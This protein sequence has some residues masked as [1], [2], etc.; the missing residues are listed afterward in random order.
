VGSKIKV[1]G[2]EADLIVLF[3]ELVASLRIDCLRK[4]VIRKQVKINPHLKYVENYRL[5]S[6][7]CSKMVE[8]KLVSKDGFYCR[9]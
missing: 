5:K 3:T 8:D 9:P 7:N 6:T 2:Q 1:E 4:E